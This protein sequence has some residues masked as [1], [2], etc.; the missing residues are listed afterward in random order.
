MEGLLIAEEI[1][2]VGPL[3][4]SERLS[5]RFPDANTFVL[6][7]ARGAIWLYVKPPN[8]RFAFRDDYPG[9]TRASGP[10][11]ELLAA[12]AA[13]PLRRLE[14]RKLD[15]VMSLHF[16]GASGFVDTAPV[17]LIAE[18]T[19][20]NANLILTSEQGIILGAL[21]EVGPR[22]NRYRQVR[23]GLAYVPPPPYEKIDPRSASPDTLM[24]AL[25]GSRAKELGKVIDGV[26]PQLTRAI[27]LRAGLEGAA[28]LDRSA[29]SRLVPV[30]REAAAGP[31]RILDELPDAGD[32]EALRQRERRE[33]QLARAKNA[34][35]KRRETAKRRL[36]D[37]DKAAA[38]AAD[39]H[40]L[41]RQADLL[42]AYGHSVPKGVDKVE[43][44]DFDGRPVT[45]GLDAK[46]SAHENAEALY[47][48]ARKREL[49]YRLS[50][51]RRDELERELRQAEAQ[52]E[53]L[54]AMSEQELDALAADA[55]ERDLRARTRSLPGIR[56]TSPQG[57]RV[58][59][60]RNAKDNEAV[61]FKIARSRDVWLH[62]QG[63]TGSHVI[64]QAENREVPFETILYGAQLAAGYSQARHSDNVP[65]D[66]T[67][68]K[69][70][71]RPKGGPT[72]AVH[73][74]QQK[75]VYVTPSRQPEGAESAGS[76]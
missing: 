71:W 29:S 11:Q 13:G 64:I 25:E 21:R 56:Y 61:T 76:T 33:T 16:A 28:K 65:V 4:P 14:Q 9:T 23:S 69:H 18:L 7:L 6:P 59:V 3:L 26:G 40:S 36:T 38:A 50:G 52:L 73:F 74:T 22:D 58:L 41:R 63:Y 43:L 44:N 55:D 57:F 53:R 24:K 45:I 2:Q 5:W 48:R 8:A 66:Y 30:I 12:R 54:Q 51:E 42:L 1:A 70:V 37:I 39:A 49:R 17:V 35:L 46:L 20:R 32:I 27:A 60:G 75:T 72:G 19:G 15:R 31:K 62:A 10:F 67:L 47:R 68:K 34:L